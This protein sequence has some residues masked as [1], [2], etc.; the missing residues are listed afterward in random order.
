MEKYL[1]KRLEVGLAPSVARVSFMS[2]RLQVMLSG[3]SVPGYSSVRQI[4]VQGVSGVSEPSLIWA[5]ESLNKKE[6]QLR[7]NKKR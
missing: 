4:W 2:P 5:G 6:R 7:N 3:V 1:R